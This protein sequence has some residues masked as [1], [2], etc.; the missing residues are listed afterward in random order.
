MAL[1]TEAMPMLRKNA[2]AMSQVAKSATQSIGLIA[3]IIPTSV[4]TPL[5]PDPFKKIE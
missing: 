5:P 2:S 3:N 4:A 1:I